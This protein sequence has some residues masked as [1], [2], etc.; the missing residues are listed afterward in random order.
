[1]FSFVSLAI[2]IVSFHNNRNSKTDTQKQPHRKCL[3]ITAVVCT[4]LHMWSSPSF[5]SSKAHVF[6]IA[7][8][9]TVY[10]EGKPDNTPGKFIFLKTAFSQVHMQNPPS[11][12]SFPGYTLQLLPKTTS[13]YVFRAELHII[14]RE[15]G[16]ILRRRDTSFYDGISTVTKPGG[17]HPF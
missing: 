12:K 3:H 6:F 14:V 15:G 13:S 7:L 2:V 9:F 10:R 5:F 8:H 4:L 1:M 11:H 16:C 17:G